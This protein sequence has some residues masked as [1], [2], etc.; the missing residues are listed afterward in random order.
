MVG[1]HKQEPIENLVINVNDEIAGT[2]IDKI[3]QRKGMMMTM[4]SENGLTTLEF[5]IPMPEQYTLP[6]NP[7]LEN[8]MAA[9][10]IQHP[11]YENKLI[12]ELQL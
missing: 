1:G 7:P 12:G 2:I 3:N 6:I 4:N 9:P 5:E 8:D 10:V 11:E